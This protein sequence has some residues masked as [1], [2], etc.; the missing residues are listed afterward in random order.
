MDNIVVDENTPL[1]ALNP[2]L[3]PATQHKKNLPSFNPS[4]QVNSVAELGVL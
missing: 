1:V 2:L 4:T 3:Y